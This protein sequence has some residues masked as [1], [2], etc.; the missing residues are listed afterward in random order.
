MLLAVPGKPVGPLLITDIQK[1]SLT[2]N[3]EAP[4]S[5]GGTPITGYVIEMK[6][7]LTSSGQNFVTSLRDVLS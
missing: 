3:W 4:T 6:D 5:H 7:V 2:L 1:S